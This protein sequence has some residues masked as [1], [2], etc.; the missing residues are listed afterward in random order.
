MSALD[1]EKK[2]GLKYHYGMP[3]IFVPSNLHIEPRVYNPS[4]AKNLSYVIYVYQRL[5]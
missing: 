5:K 2:N 4:D 3:G 1:Q